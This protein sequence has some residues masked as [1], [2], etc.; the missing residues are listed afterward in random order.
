M[1]FIVECHLLSFS[2]RAASRANKATVN[3]VRQYV[4]R[5][6]YCAMLVD[7]CRL[8]LKKTL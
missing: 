2:L 5:V 8:P 1:R 4:T 6:C 3:I 7:I